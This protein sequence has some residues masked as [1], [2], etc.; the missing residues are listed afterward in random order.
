M[1]NSFKKVIEME[2]PMRF[3]KERMKIRI[4]GFGK[5][6]DSLGMGSRDA[7]VAVFADGDRYSGREQQAHAPNHHALSL[8]DQRKPMG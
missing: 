4:N 1:V 6:G 5:L 7:P 3:W 2:R 8:R